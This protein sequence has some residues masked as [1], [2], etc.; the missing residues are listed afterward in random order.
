[1]AEKGS[2]KNKRA[3]VERNPQ[4]KILSLMGK[5]DYDPTYD[6]KAERRRDNS[7]IV[8]DTG[9]PPVK[10]IKKSRKSH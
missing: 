6:Y 3:A 9:F 8:E 1:M 4:L 7:R 2:G 5:I 10:G